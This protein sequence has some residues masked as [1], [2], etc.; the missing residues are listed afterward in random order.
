MK[1]VQ[2]EIPFFLNVFI[3]FLNRVIFLAG[4]RQA[5]AERYDVLVSNGQRL[6][7][8]RRQTTVEPAN[9][10]VKISFMNYN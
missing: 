8:S 7:A 2:V 6:A 10:H 4:F 9:G 5:C 3:L 1:H